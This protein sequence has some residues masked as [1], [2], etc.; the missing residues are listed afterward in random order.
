L[1]AE[2]VSNGDFSGGST[3][4]QTTD[5]ITIAGGV[6]DYDGV[7]SYK[8]LYQV[9]DDMTSALEVNKDYELKFDVVADGTS[10]RIRLRSAYGEYEYIATDNYA[11]GSHTLEISPPADIG[12]YGGIRFQFY[13]T[14]G[15]GTVDNI[16]IKEKL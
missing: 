9:N 11:T 10:I 12:T 7:D 1:G 4:W 8:S 3:D 2:K 16:S 14:N 15:G 6:A 13:N 5:G